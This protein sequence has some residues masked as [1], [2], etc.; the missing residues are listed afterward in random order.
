[1]KFDVIETAYGY[2]LQNGQFTFVLN[3][4]KKVNSSAAPYF[5]AQ[6]DPVAKFISGMFKSKSKSTKPIMKFNG[7]YLT[8]TVIVI[9]NEYNLTSNIYFNDRRKSE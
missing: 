4:T 9:I 1:M 3:E 2:K 7:K 5:L 8:S 6:V